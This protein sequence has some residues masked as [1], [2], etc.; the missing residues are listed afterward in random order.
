[1]PIDIPNLVNT[2][3]NAPIANADPIDPNTIASPGQASRHQVKYTNGCELDALF[4]NKGSET[5]VVSFHGALNRTSFEIPR[6]E[7][8]KSLLKYDCNSLFISDPALHL[9]ENLQLSWYTSWEGA[10]VQDD[11][12]RL[13]EGIAGLTGTRDTI[14]TGSSG[15]GFAALQI[16]ALM[17]NTLALPFNPQTHIHGYLVD[18]IDGAHGAER[19]YLEVVH[20]ERVVGS[21]W[22]TDFDVDWTEALSDEVSALRRYSTPVPNRV[23]YCQTPTDWHYYQHYLPFLAAAAKGNNLSRILVHEYGERVGHF[24]PDA[25]EFDSALKLAFELSKQAYRD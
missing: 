14:L 4:I 24:P 11:V 19:K 3:Y 22:D 18:G 6:F 12:A 23:L 10:E 7:R 9:D 1:M 15:G 25:D 16:S 13:I 8:L 20:P 17:P 2:G 5:L 21:I